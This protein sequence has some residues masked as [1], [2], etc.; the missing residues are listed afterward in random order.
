[1]ISTLKKK[2]N[3]KGFTLAELLVVVAI[4]AVLVAIAI[5][6]FSSALDKARISADEANVRSWYAEQTVEYL[7]ATYDGSTA[8]GF[9]KT[10]SETA[11]GVT[12]GKVAVITDSTVKYLTYKYGD[13]AATT[14]AE[15]DYAI[16]I[17]SNIIN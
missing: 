3:K 5:P 7:S 2:L 9:P 1:M 17:D 11:C 8:T 10:A 6:V 16:E 15:A 12:H 14:K 4:I 13:T